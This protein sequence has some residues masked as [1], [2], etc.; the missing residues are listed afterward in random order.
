MHEK[1]FPIRRL[2]TR[3]LAVTRDGY[4]NGF[5]SVDV[6]EAFRRMLAR[7]EVPDGI[8]HLLRESRESGFV[9][10]VTV[11]AFLILNPSTKSL[12]CCRIRHA[13]DTVAPQ[14]YT[15]CH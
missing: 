10:A 14:G 3:R 13:T 2:W 7:G 9:G 6:C 1:N 5:V 4:D 8:D 11:R 15:A 12:S